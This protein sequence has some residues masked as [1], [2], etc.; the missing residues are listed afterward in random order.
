MSDR[1]CCDKE[2]LGASLGGRDPAIYI[3]T[4]ERQLQPVGQHQP[5]VKKA[6]L[7]ER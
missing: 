5:R 7:V 4:L 6:E 1:G 3:P 2:F